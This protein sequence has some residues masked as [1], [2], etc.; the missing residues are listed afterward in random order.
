[1]SLATQMNAFVI[2]VAEEFKATFAK[3]GD[4]SA[5][6]TVNKI[7]LVAAI[8]ELAARPA[9]GGVQIDD[10]TASLTTV[11]SSTKTNAQIQAAIDALVNGAPGALDT[12]KELADALEGNEAQITDI[13]TALGNRVRFDA[14]QTLTAEQQEQARQNIGAASAA[15]VGDT[16]TN[17]VAAFNTALAS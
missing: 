14:A 7:S 11:Y 4:N 13:M 17:F 5:L 6:T 12:L 3:M 16:E 2:R 8:N 15:G 1:M 10:A 9:D